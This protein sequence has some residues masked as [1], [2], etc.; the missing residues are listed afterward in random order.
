MIYKNKR[1]D[2]PEKLNTDQTYNSIKIKLKSIIDLNIK[3]KTIKFLEEN[4]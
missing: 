1:I 4:I 3:Y 2:K